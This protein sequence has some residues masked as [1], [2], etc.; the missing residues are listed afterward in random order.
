MEPPQLL[1]RRLFHE[2]EHRGF[3]C[4]STGPC[5]RLSTRFALVHFLACSAEPA[6]LKILASK[7]CLPRAPLDYKH[8]GAGLALLLCLHL[9]CRPKTA[10]LPQPKVKEFFLL[11]RPAKRLHHMHRKQDAAIN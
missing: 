2:G 3:S 1:K 9:R 6:D 5:A 8:R 11:S 10:D 7:L 4:D